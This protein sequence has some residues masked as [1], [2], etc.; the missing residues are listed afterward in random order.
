MKAVQVLLNNDGTFL[1]HIEFYSYPG[2]TLTRDELEEL[3][4]DIQMQLCDS[5][6]MQEKQ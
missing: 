6:E 4:D 1:L 2:I 5:E 3:R